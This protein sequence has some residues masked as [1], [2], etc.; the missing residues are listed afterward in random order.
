MASAAKD[1]GTKITET[2]APVACTAS[3]TLSKMGTWLSN[4]WPPFAGGDA[5]DDSG[6]VGQA[7]ARVLRAEVAGD[8][9]YKDLGVGID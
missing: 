9:L 4:R 5:A 1:G 3:V 7:Q 8:A 6:A 2:V